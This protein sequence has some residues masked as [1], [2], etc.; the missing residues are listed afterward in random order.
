V[1]AAD[2]VGAERVDVLGQRRGEASELDAVGLVLELVEGVLDVD[3]VP[4]DDR[5]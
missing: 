2:V 3:G 4:V 1:V 5:A